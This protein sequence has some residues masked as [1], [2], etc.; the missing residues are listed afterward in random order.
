MNKF[1]FL[2][3]LETFFDEILTHLVLS[4]RNPCSGEVYWDDLDYITDKLPTVW[5][6]KLMLIITTTLILSSNVLFK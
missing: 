3:A 6:L 4:I 5:L 2:H 1:E